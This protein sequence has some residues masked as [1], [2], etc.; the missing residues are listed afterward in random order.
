MESVVDVSRVTFW[1]GS[2]IKWTGTKE[3]KAFSMRYWVGKLG[4][5]LL[6][7]TVELSWLLT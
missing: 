5:L 2:K 1:S 6:S 3:W 4:P 7:K